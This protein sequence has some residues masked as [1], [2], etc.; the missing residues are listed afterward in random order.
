MKCGG[1]YQDFLQNNY[2]FA[3]LKYIRAGWPTRAGTLDD[4]AQIDGIVTF[5]TTFSTQ[6]ER[7]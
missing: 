5:Y 6:L 3:L 2:L 1:D 4:Q 7:K